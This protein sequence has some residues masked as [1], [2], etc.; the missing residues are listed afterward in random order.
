MVI[1]FKS[2]RIL[3]HGCANILKFEP[4]QF[5]IPLDFRS[6]QCKGKATKQLECALKILC[7]F[8]FSFAAQI[9]SNIEDDAKPAELQFDQKKT[10]VFNVHMCSH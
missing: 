3:A 5:A 10:W 9:F 2:W 8:F 4:V 6:N 1:F 7:M